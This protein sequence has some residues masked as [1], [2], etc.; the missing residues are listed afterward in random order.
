MFSRG[1]L[2]PGWVIVTAGH[3]FGAKPDGFVLS[4]MGRSWAKERRLLKSEVGDGT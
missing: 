4:A 3:R 1:S 2:A